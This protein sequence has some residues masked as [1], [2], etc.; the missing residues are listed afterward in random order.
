MQYVY[1]TSFN[2]Y[3]MGYGAAMSWLLFVLIAMMWSV[4]GLQA[5]RWGASSIEVT[6]ASC[7]LALPLLG[8]VAV[9]LPVHMAQVPLT[10][11]LL[12]A[13]YQ[14]VLVGVV[15]LY[16]YARTVAM[17]GAAR[18]TLFLPLVPVVTASCSALL[19]AEYP[20]PAEIAG[21]AVVISGML[22]AFR[23]PSTG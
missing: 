9:A 7:V 12:Q 6:V 8:I 11:V 22:V 5:R 21:M 20:S 13:V 2:N 4:F 19:L 14:G 23:S 1:E 16:L 3:H 18:A 15:A 10:E 17:L